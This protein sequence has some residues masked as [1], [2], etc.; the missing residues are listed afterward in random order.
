MPNYLFEFVQRFPY[1]CESQKKIG[2]YV[3]NRNTKTHKWCSKNIQHF[4][5]LKPLDIN[6]ILKMIFL[7][8]TW[9]MIS[10]FNLIRVEILGS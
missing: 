6:D 5:F 10:C 8:S 3:R 2:F 7:S 4:I 1:Q 9:H